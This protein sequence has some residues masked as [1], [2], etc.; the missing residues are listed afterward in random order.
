[1]NFLGIGLV[2]VAVIL[3]VAFLVLGPSKSIDLARSG[4][5][6]VRNLRSALADLT[7]AVDLERVEPTDS[8]GAP[9]PPPDPGEAPTPRNQ[10]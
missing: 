1:V 5:R 9:P 6:L 10:R 2:E 3:L 7:T 4:G 8:G